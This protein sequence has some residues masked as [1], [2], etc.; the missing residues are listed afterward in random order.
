VAPPERERGA[1]RSDPLCD[2]VHA[3]QDV[4]QAAAAAKL[5]ADVA[6]AAQLACARDDEIAEAAQTREGV[7]A[8]ALCA[9]EP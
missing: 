4:A 2:H 3:P 6:V 1:G 7:A 5:D 9:C 8:A